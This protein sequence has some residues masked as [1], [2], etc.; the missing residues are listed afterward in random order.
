[1]DDEATKKAATNNN[2]NCNKDDNEK[3]VA[4]DD[5]DY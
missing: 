3:T 4:I 5:N 1:M 2:T